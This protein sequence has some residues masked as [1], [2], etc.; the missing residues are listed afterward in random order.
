M[1]KVLSDWMVFVYA[2][3]YFVCSVVCFLMDN[4][5]LWF[6]FFYKQIHIV[7]PKFV[8]TEHKPV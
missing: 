8:N 5:L 1:I 6:G 2:E 4:N 7:A 3:N